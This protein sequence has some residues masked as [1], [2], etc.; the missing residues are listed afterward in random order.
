MATKEFAELQARLAAL[1]AQNAELSAKLAS[2]LGKITIKMSSKGGVSV[3]GLQRFP[4]TLYGEQWDRLLAESANI[5][6]FMDANRA[7]LATK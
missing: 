7:R 3:Y 4:V 5:K 6:A 1:T 2:R